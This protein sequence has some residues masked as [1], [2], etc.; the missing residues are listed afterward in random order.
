MN[1]QQI[2]PKYFSEA[3]RA[4]QTYIAAEPMGQGAVP[5]TTMTYAPQVSYITAPLELPR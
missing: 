5:R 2:T 4:N 1:L 3:W